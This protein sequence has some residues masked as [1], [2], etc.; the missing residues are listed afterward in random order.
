MFRV[1]EQKCVGCG[2]CVNNCPG[3]TQIESDGKASIIDQEKLEKCGGERVCGFGAI[4]KISEGENPEQQAHS[5]SPVFPPLPPY[6]PSP[7]DGR[8]LGRGKGPGWSR[9]MGRRWR[10]GR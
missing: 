1:N 4:E 6:G 8:G 7:S 3:A 9:G 5:T 10:G 2:V